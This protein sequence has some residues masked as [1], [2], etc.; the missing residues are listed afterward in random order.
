MAHE[1]GD[2]INQLDPDN[3][4]G[5]DSIS[6]GD[7]HLRLLKKVLKQSFPNVN[8]PV[9]AIHTGPTPPTLHSPGTVWFDTSTG[10]V[11]M[12]DK[13][14]NVW[15]KM[16]HGEANGIGQLLRA[17]WYESSGKTFR[18]N[19]N[20]IIRVTISPLSDT[21][22][23][24][25]NVSGEA[26]VW[27]DINANYVRCKFMDLTTGVQIGQD[28]LVAGFNHVDDMGNFEIFSTLNMKEIYQNHPSTTF[29]VAMIAWCSS[30]DSGGGGIK[31]INLEVLEI[32]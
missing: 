24:F 10:L 4:R 23:Y 3:P 19:E 11:K 16:A 2:Y 25:F 28:T 30:P 14:D 32:E 5:T 21:S 29:D 18:W 22:T 12:R 13:D 31:H 17:D 27:A 8:E 15:L 20:E 1:S 7:I 6:E 9:N 26:S